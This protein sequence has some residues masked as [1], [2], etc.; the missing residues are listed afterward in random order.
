MTEYRYPDR[1]YLLASNASKRVF[2]RHSRTFS[3]TSFN[4]RA[5]FFGVPG[6]VT[7]PEL[8][9]VRMG[10]KSCFWCDSA[11]TEAQ[12][13]AVDHIW[14][15]SKGGWN[16][17][18]NMVAACKSC[19][20]SKGSRSPLDYAVERVHPSRLEDAK[21]RIAL[22]AQGSGSTLAALQTE[23]SKV[24]IYYQFHAAECLHFYVAPDYSAFVKALYPFYLS[25]ADARDHVRIVVSKEGSEGRPWRAFVISDD[26]VSH[27]AQRHIRASNRLI[28]T[29]DF[30][31][32]CGA[33][34][35]LRSKKK[36]PDRSGAF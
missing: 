20:S 3:A 15:L 7:E 16:I 25:L 26:G 27:K 12:R 1:Y 21:R 34:P 14:P 5:A 30:V 22:A 17:A 8:Y 35:I 29:P 4:A 18:L 9:P 19:N 6:I 32:V 36:A 24:C 10:R 33:K 13:A 23:T 11:F 31:P 2:R 28:P